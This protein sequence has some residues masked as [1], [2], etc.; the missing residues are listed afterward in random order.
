[1]MMEEIK[2]QQII[3]KAVGVLQIEI[4]GLETLKSQIGADFVR[5]TEACLKTLESG[6]KIVVTGIGKS[7]HIGSKIAAT[8]ASTGSTAIFMHPVEAMHGDLGMLQENDI[9]IALS[10]SGET[11]ELT[12]MIVP[13]KRLGVPVA[14]FTGYPESTLAKLSDIVVIGAVG[15]EACPFNLAPTTTSTAHLAL[16]DAL[17]M[18]LLEQRKFTKE[19]FGRRHPGGAIGRAVTMRVGDLMRKG[20]SIVLAKPEDTVKTTLVRMT[21]ARCGSAIITDDAGAL[22]GIFT[23]GDFRRRVENDLSILTRPMSE[24]MTKDPVTVREDSLAVEVLKIVEKRK[25]DDLVVLT[26]DG[27]VGGLVDIQDLPG[28]K[29]M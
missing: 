10:Y 3:E 24:V 18:A 23:D 22:L 5:L 9:M 12:R 19:D 27:E 4:E 20:A 11:Q 25:I 17:A 21:A 8:L 1:M 29:L 6:G 14:C 13:A 15:R 2:A 26:A 7:G 16:G 28:F